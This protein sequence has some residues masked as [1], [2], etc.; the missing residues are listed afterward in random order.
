MELLQALRLHL[1]ASPAIAALVGDRVG[2]GRL[3]DNTLYPAIALYRISTPRRMHMTGVSG[4]VG[5]RIQIS[6]FAQRQD[7]A[8]ELGRE[9]TAALAGFRG[10]M[11]GVVPVD[12]ALPEDDRDGVEPNPDVYSRLL[13]FFIWHREAA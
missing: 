7:K 13:D 1:Q 8:D 6:C 9:V 12:G 5:P 3:A 2:P 10:L 4:L 11:A